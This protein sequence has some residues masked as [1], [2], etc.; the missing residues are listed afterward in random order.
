LAKI[1]GQCVTTIRR[2]RRRYGLRPS[3]CG[4]R[5]LAKKASLIFITF[6]LCSPGSIGGAQ[7]ARYCG[8]FDVDRD[9]TLAPSVIFSRA[10]DAW[11]SP[12]TT[13]TIKYTVTTKGLFADGRA[14]ARHYAGFYDGDGRFK[15]SRFSGEEIAQPAI[16]RGI[17]VDL[18]LSLSGG[19][20]VLKRLSRDPEPSDIL[21][22]PS[23]SPRYSFGIARSSEDIPDQDRESPDGLRV[24]GRVSIERP[25][26]AVKL[27]GI[28][29]IDSRPAYHLALTPTSDAKQFRLREM[30]VDRST[31][32]TRRI[33]TD[34]NFTDRPSLDV[35]WLITFQ[36]LN[37]VQYL[38]QEESE[39]P[40][41]WKRIHYRQV[42]ISF[43][44]LAEVSTAVP[45]IDF[46]LPDADG[47]LSEP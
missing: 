20:T 16:A 18:V 45:S 6:A 37:H 30:W 32:E 14:V 34:G 15:V 35:S 13:T 3:R 19:T 17:N 44:D 23:L 31:F 9:D 43:D 1:T 22:F 28:D 36:T 12:E 40:L 33:R 41:V 42:T 27:I 29:S 38:R 8:A 26:Y 25:Q 5:G 7:V 46:R 2:Q 24:I 11:A 21:G 39:A 10:R 47:Q 4:V